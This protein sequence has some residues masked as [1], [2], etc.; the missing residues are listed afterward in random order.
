MQQDMEKKGQRIRDPVHGL[1]A[2]DGNDDFERLCW[3]LI[4]CKEFQRLRRIKQLGFS[5]LVY[6]GASH[7][8]FA[9]SL[10]V[11][12]T[13]RTL[14]G[15]LRKKLGDK[16]RPER[17]Q[18][19]LCAA[20]LHD[21]GHG[22][23]SHTFEGVLKKRKSHK[24]H[25][26][27][28]V[29]IIQ[30]DTEIGKI[31]SQ[32]QQ[33][34]EGVADLLGREFPDDVYA[35]IVSSQF[36][37]DRLDYLQRDRLMTGTEYGAFDLEWILNNLEIANLT[38]G[39]D[40]KIPFQVEG[41]ILG[42][43]GLYAAESYLLGRFHL[44]MQ[45]Y[46]HKTTRAAEK[47]LEALLGIVADLIASDEV[48]K[49][50]LPAEHP[51][52]RFF[53]E[54]GGSLENYLLLDDATIWGALPL[55]ENSQNENLAEL[56]RRLCHRRLYKCL[57]IGALAAAAGGDSQGRFSKSLHDAR[58]ERQFGNIDVFE[59]RAPVSAYKYREYESQDALSKIMIRRADGSGKHEDV[60]KISKVIEAL[61]EQRIFRVYARNEQVKVRLMKIWSEAAT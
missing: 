28:T 3:R 48:V 45:V 30:S 8:R 10:G 5:E 41:L 20:L 9:H 38:I 7:T 18:I 22:P 55:L 43:K 52:V 11:F 59:D 19:A 4:N 2:F 6:P 61:G 16:F 58:R 57:D 14:V 15:V 47:M 40:D 50:G 44:Y 21:L 31:L 42:S 36:D 29:E 24:K 12:H 26:K 25:E 34:R 32:N 60:A 39:D 51:L 33:L 1:I 17:A 35:S 53:R 27:W 56:A 54:D 23:F 46:M 37:A 49:T 13:A